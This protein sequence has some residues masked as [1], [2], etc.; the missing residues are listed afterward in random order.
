VKFL[1]EDEELRRHLLLNE[2]DEEEW[3]FWRNDLA[4]IDSKSISSGALI[5]D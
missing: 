1:V 2:R 4:V 3:W 5:D